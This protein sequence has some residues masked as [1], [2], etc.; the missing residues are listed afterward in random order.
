[1]KY[2]KPISVELSDIEM[3]TGDCVSGTLPAQRCADGGNNVGPC[4][5][6][7]NAGQSCAEGTTPY[8]TRYSE[9]LTGE[10]ATN[11][12]SGHFAGLE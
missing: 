12:R 2:Q 3:A 5:L 10:E 11:C 8:H 4:A 9:C 1:M 6:G 7:T